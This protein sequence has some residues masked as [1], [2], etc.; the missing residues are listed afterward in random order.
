ML[1]QFLLSG[2][3]SICNIA[4]HAA[5]MTAVVWA[6]RT[7]ATK[8]LLLPGA[9]LTAVMIC[10]VSLMIAHVMEVIVWS[11]AYAIVDTA[12]TTVPPKKPARDAIANT[13]KAANGTAG[14]PA[15]LWPAPEQW[16]HRFDGA[17]TL[18]HIV[19]TTMVGSQQSTL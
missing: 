13:A 4:I 8:E 19:E 5:V 9:R 10:I 6:A 16:V 1:R 15:T 18:R 3:V 17:L 14:S 2:A 12:P 11:L 7:A